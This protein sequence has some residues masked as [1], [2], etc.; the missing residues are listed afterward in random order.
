VPD[1]KHQD[2]FKRNRQNA[3]RRARNRSYRTRMRTEIK[4]LRTAIE[5]GDSQA[6]ATQ[7]PLTVSMIHRL[8]QK[9]IIHQKQA[10]RRVSRLSRSVNAL[11]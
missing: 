11:G 7:L 5:A 6:A 8:A 2:A 1:H 10:A 4:K 9:G 3:K